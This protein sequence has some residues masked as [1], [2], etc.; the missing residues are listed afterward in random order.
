MKKPEH[1][2]KEYVKTL[3]DENLK[4]IHTRYAS[5]CQGDRAEIL[6]IFSKNEEVDRWLR[7]ADSAGDLFDMLDYLRDFV[8]REYKRRLSQR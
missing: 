7:G 8:E 6:S 4:F 3:S 5:L 2:L 1:M